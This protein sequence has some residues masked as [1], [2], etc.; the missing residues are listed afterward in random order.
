MV[1][2]HAIKNGNLINTENA[3]VNIGRRDV[4]FSFSVY[5]SLRIVEGRAVFF[6]DH[7]KRLESSAKGIK[8]KNSFCADEIDKWIKLLIKADDID[9]ATIRIYLVGGVD[10]FITASPI[11]AYP[12]SYYENGV[13][14]YTY[15]GERLFPQFK[16]SNLLMSYIALEDSKAKGGFE[17]ILEN[18]D[19][20][21]LEGTRSNF[22]ALKG[23]E[24]YTANDELVLSGVTRTRVLKIA[25]DKG[26][27]IVFEAPKLLD[28]KKGLY[29]EAFISSTSM[30]TMPIKSIDEYVFNSNFKQTMDLHILIRKLESKD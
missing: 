22:Y 18:R 3:V 14:T 10:L 11:L 21:L 7:M 24:L 29:D 5:E 15:K 1:G 12:D 27:K 6:E 8:M 20:C 2:T 4:Q 26:Y 25:K 19:G 30:A 13:I 17:S 23:D 9:R 28:I 16:T